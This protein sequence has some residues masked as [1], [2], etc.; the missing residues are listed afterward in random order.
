MKIKK[1]ERKKIF[2]EVVK[3]IMYLIKSGELKENDKLP[4]EIILAEKFG[5][6]RPTVREA[7]SALEVGGII[8]SKVGDGTYVKVTKNFNESLE[9]NINKLI[10][11]EEIPQEIIESRKIIEPEICALVAIKANR[12]DKNRIRKALN[13]IEEE[14][15]ENRKWSELSDKNLHLEILYTIDNNIIV[16]F[17]SDVINLMEQNIYMNLRDKVLEDPSKAEYYI[18]QHREIVNAINRNDSVLAKSLMSKHLNDMENE[19]L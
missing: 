12:N 2:L 16:K 5:V 7:L 18:N 6:S 14:Y 1:I 11:S 17:V 4:P 9:I 3:Q 8:T 10:N 13:R 19:I 15:K